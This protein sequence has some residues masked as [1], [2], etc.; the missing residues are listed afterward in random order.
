MVRVRGHEL[1]AELTA[2]SACAELEEQ[3]QQR[4]GKLVPCVT[5]V[6][7]VVFA[8]HVAQDG[9]TYSGI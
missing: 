5:G 8:L 2:A 6:Y 1:V 4:T 3:A 9:N 7:D